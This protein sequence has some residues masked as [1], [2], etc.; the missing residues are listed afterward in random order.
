[1]LSG[2]N[3]MLGRGW[4][5]QQPCPVATAAT[6]ATATAATTTMAQQNHVDVDALIEDYAWRYF[7]DIQSLKRTR[8]EEFKNLEREDVEFILVH[9]LLH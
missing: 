7:R 3:R 9:I 8:L 1:M 4:L 2:S 5:R 6:A